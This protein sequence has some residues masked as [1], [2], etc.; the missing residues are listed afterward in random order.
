MN[1]QRIGTL[2]AIVAGLSSFIGCGKKRG[3][4]LHPAE[5]ASHQRMLSELAEIEK[6]T[7]E[8]N[9][10]LSDVG[11]KRIEQELAKNPNLQKNT[12]I[13]TRLQIDLGA[14]KLQYGLEREAIDHLLELRQTVSRRKDTAKLI[15]I[16]FQLAVAWLR[17]AENENCCAK[18]GPESCIFPL[19]GGAIHQAR[20]GSENAV[21][22]LSE[23]LKQPTLSEMGRARILWLLNITHMTLGESVAELPEEWR[24]PDP[25]SSVPDGDFPRFKNIAQ[26][27]GV[28]TF[29]LSGGAIM[30]D[31][32]GDGWFDL[33]VSS[34]NPAVSMKYF[35]NRRDGTFEDLTERANLEGIKGGLNLK[36]VDFDNDGDLDIYVMRG[37]WMQKYGR[38]PNSLLQNDGSGRFTDVTYAVGLGL[39]A[40]PNQAADWADFDLD[41]DLDL[42]VGNES[43]RGFKSPVEFYRNDGPDSRGI[44]QFTEMATAVGLRGFAYVKGVS[45]GDFDGDRFPDLF[46]SCLDEK[47]HLFRNR[48]DGTFEGVTTKHGV[49]EPLRSFPTWFWD[50]NNDGHL[51]L[52]VSTYL[53]AG[54]QVFHHAK[55]RRMPDTSIPRLYRND[56]NGGFEEV[57]R[58]SGLDQPMLPMGSNFG[59]LTN[60]GFPDFYLGTGDPSLSSVV[61]NQLMSNE[62]GYFVDRTVQSGTG[63]LQK[64]HAVSMADFD[65]DGDL[66]IFEQMGGAFLG[67]PYYDALYENPGGGGNWISVRLRGV[68]S[69]SFGVGSRVAILVERKDGTER[70]FY[71]WMNSGGSFGANPLELHMGLGDAKSIRR[72][73]IRW[74]KKTEKTQVLEAVEMNRRIEIRE[75]S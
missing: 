73:E 74:P 11:I 46:L 24:L 58:Q 71:R 51:D 45:W 66:D 25:E 23:L 36:Q 72:I 49:S 62:N 9:F 68:Q 39:S 40:F 38:H 26:A 20:E 31:F 2:L 19:K 8:E 33:A 43:H 54:A 55:G 32:D 5:A 57:A 63:H 13:F 18:P 47:N 61:P 64:G 48:G 69:N 65:R 70:W 15:D 1:I 50:Y 14:K 37:A 28:D 60:D 12:E 10:Y 27:A 30:D 21:R 17:I 6:Q 44:T 56:G 53:G 35:R 34:W 42:F 3:L 7:L 4:K 75:E 29:G 52:F 22:I 41:G 16:D 67:D 59:D